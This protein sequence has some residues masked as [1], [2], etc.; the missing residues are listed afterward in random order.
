MPNATLESVCC[1]E[2]KK[3]QW[4]PSIKVGRKFELFWVAKRCQLI[5]ISSELESL[6]KHLGETQLS[7]GKLGLLGY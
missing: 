3:K 1:S 4:T 5:N 7:D 6:I 2:I